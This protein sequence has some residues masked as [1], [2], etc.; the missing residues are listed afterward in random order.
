MKLI[1]QRVV[2][3]SD[4]AS[5]INA[6]CYLHP[7]AVW[8]DDPQEDLG[9]GILANRIVEVP[10]GGNRVRSY[11]EVTTPDGTSNGAI[12]AAVLSGADLLAASGRELPWQ[13]AHG[14]TRFTF[15]LELALAEHWLMELKILLGYTLE[16]RSVP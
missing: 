6:Y 16:V 3:P 1:A 15:N 12:T 11:L 13:L 8:L 2:R 10:P 4:H 5:G 14:E 9:R 7:G